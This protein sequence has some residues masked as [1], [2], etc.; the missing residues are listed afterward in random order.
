MDFV[1]DHIADL[2]RWSRSHL[3]EVALAVTATLLVLFGSQVT[4]SSRR[5]W[6]A[7]RPPFGYRPSPWPAW[8]SMAPP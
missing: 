7:C 1:L 8:P 3:D 2:S 6:A 4:P 5:G